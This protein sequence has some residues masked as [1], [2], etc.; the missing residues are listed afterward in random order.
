MLAA[1]SRKHIAMAGRLVGWSRTQAVPADCLCLR[2]ACG[3]WPQAARRS[4]R[5]FHPLQWAPLDTTDN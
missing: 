3:L 2:K 5:K 4:A 1:S